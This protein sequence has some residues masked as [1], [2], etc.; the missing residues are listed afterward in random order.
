MRIIA[1]TRRLAILVVAFGLVL[2]FAIEATITTNG[3]VAAQEPE[4]EHERILL[5][6]SPRIWRLRGLLSHEECDALIAL[7][8]QRLK[9]SEMG[10]V[11]G[12]ATDASDAA[13]RRTSSST[14]FDAP[15]EAPD[16]LLQRLRQRWA[17]VAGE[18]I[19]LAE[20]TQIT[21]YGKGEAYGLHLDAS[22]EVLRRATVL[23]YLSDGF[24]GGETSFPRVAAAQAQG[25]RLRGVMKPL[26]KLAAA[27][28]LAQ[29]LGKFDEY[30]SDKRAVLRAAARKGDALLFFPLRPDDLEPD[31]DAV[32][33]GCPVRSDG[34]P[35][36]I[37]Q[38]WFTSVRLRK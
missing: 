34:E 1:G 32:H 16:A 36:W 9:A 24:G 6:D 18:P 27:G 17:D 13:S 12:D 30:C 14:V 10:S 37:S 3:E 29:E 20:P 15:E 31:H 2:A 33:G 38:Q 35:K 22:D 11:N 21:R 25:S 4:Q 28:L 23:T 26:E 8:E 19:A 5:S 7:G